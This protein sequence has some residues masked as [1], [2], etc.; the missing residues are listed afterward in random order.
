MLGAE[1]EMYGRV[2]LGGTIGW[3][4]A[5]PLAGMLVQAYGLKLAFWGY[6]LLMFLGLIVSQGLR[7]GKSEKGISILDGLR[8]LLA[9][10]GSISF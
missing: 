5:A 4:L 3:G 10:R 6:A 9:S 7:Y 2:R 8:T 1:K